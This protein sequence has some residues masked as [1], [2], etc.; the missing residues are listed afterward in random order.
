MAG[1]GAIERECPAF[2]AKRK[3]L[4][5]R[6]PDYTYC[7]FPTND[8]STWEYEGDGEMPE[9]NSAADQRQGMMQGTNEHSRLTAGVGDRGPRTQDTGWEGRR[10]E[11]AAK[12]ASGSRTAAPTRANDGAGGQL[13]QTRLEEVMQG[14]AAE[15][16]NRE[17]DWDNQM[18][19]ETRRDPHPLPDV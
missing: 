19:E 9:A 4:H 17:T 11:K 15:R 2:Q 12:V 10:G 5:K 14:G 8:P 7:L 3:A 6:F 1:H 13:R 16:R 18:D